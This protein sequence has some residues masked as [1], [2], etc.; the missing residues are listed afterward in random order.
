MA[1]YLD[2]NHPSISDE[3]HNFIGD[4]NRMF[5]DFQENL[6]FTDDQI[7]ELKTWIVNADNYQ[8]KNRKTGQ[9][10]NY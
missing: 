2:L 1:Q 7:E 4:I 6:S 8:I 9:I 10:V 3:A 5:E